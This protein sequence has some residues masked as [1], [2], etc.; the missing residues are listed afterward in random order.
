M[1][2]IGAFCSYLKFVNGDLL[3][4]LRGLRDRPGASPRQ[5]V[6]GEIMASVEKVRI[7]TG[8]N[9][10]DVLDKVDDIHDEAIDTTH[11]FPLSQVYGSYNRKLWMA[12]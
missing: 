3:P 8:K 9:L 10:C 2:K 1:W 7:D 5:K 4:H 12:V 11:V 6:I